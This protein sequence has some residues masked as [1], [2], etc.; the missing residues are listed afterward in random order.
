MRTLL[1]WVACLV[2]AGCKLQPRSLEDLVRIE[3]YTPERTAWLAEH[4]VLAHRSTMD[5]SGHLRIFRLV[6]VYPELL[7]DRAFNYVQLVGGPNGV[8]YA[9]DARIPWANPNPKLYHKHLAGLEGRTGFRCS[10]APRDPA[11]HVSGKTELSMKRRATMKPAEIVDSGGD[12]RLASDGFGEVV[13]RL[14]GFWPELGP[15]DVVVDGQVV[16]LE[17]LRQ[18]ILI[19]N[20]GQPSL[21]PD[22]LAADLAHAEAVGTRP[23]GMLPVAGSPMLEVDHAS[24]FD[25]LTGGLMSQVGVGGTVQFEE[26]T[27][28]VWQMQLVD[29][30]GKELLYAFY[31]VGE[32]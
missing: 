14:V 5:Q 29:V 15:E 27:G 16:N 18:L 26:N 6:R 9:C 7:P 4:C 11:A 24:C 2:L 31:G 22:K 21:D 10:S 13:L 19:A 25:R 23:T 30:G 20:N 28:L 8:S 32:P 17:V 12:A 3:G 1:M